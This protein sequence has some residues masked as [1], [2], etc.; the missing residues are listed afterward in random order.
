MLRL[1]LVL[2][3]MSVPVQTAKL[4][5]PAMSQTAD[6]TEPEITGKRTFGTLGRYCLVSFSAAEHCRA[7]Q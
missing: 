5:P 2:Q 3:G 6:E 7:D 1:L 4:L